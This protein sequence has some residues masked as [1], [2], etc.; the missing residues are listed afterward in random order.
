MKP[1]FIPVAF[2][3]LGLARTSDALEL[4][5]KIVAP[6]SEVREY[7]VANSI[8]KISVAHGWKCIIDPGV[9][10]KV[11][12]VRRILGHAYCAKSGEKAPVLMS[13]TF[14]C[15]DVSEIFPQQN[16]DQAIAKATGAMQASHFALIFDEK[17]AWNFHFDCIQ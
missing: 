14:S 4:K 2:L 17:E 6:N 16:S 10:D 3:A 5:L 13:H 11:K 12:D 8:I 15:A 9:D 7:Q 1:L